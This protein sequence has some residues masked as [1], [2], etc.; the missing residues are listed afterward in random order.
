MGYWS[1]WKESKSIPRKISCIES[2]SITFINDRVL[3]IKTIS[4]L[5]PQHLDGKV[6]DKHVKAN[7]IEALAMPY[8]ACWP[9]RLLEMKHAECNLKV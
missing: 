7:V 8:V 1:P 4:T 9:V 2:E 3:K 5:N 6:Q